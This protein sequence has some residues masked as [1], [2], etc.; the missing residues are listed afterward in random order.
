MEERLAYAKA[1]PAG[2]QA[3]LPLHRYV[4]GCGLEPLLLELVRMR[5]SQLN[6]CAY[7]LDM[8][9]QDA[10]ALGEREQRLYTLSAWRE[11]PFYAARE[12]AVLLWT[13]QVTLI[14]QEQ[15]PDAVYEE[16]S[17]HF[18]PEELV[19]LTLAVILINAWNRLAISFRTVPG[20]Y[21]S[22]KKPLA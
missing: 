2:Y 18:S 6:G 11:A 10:R 4:E 17:R 20:T 7:C 8:H 14:G 3:L 12:R 19:N 21:Q 13:E 5:A 9:G 1:A 22:K 15:V 16:V